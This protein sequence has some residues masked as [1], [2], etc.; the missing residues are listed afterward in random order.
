MGDCFAYALARDLR[1]L[2]NWSSRRIAA[3][4]PAQP[5][6]KDGL[7]RMCNPHWNQYTSALTAAGRPSGPGR[8]LGALPRS[9]AGVATHLVIAP[10]GPT[11][12]PTARLRG[13]GRPG[14]STVG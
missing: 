8:E 5:S 14:T 1:L 12:A 11:V 7:G 9:V 3:E 6:Q 10:R 13:H 4:F 2:T